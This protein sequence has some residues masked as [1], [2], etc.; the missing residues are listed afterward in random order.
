MGVVLD[1]LGHRARGRLTRHSD[2]H[3]REQ[4]RTGVRMYRVGNVPRIRHRFH[5]LSP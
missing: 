3:D 4:D 2:D 1:L 5:I